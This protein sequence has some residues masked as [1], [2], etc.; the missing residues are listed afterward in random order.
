MRPTRKKIGTVCV[1]SGQV[2]I[3]DPCYIDSQWEKVPVF[4]GD[5]FTQQCAD[6]KD[7][8]NYLGACHASL[9][10]N[11]AGPIGLAVAASS[12]YG[13][14]EYPVYATYE[15]GRVKSLTIKFF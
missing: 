4:P 12:G 15:G 1:D 9:S 6:N 5:N 8:F 11:M 2:M 7:Q 3:C 14:G 10:E 13:D